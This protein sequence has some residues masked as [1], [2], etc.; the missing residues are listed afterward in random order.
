MLNLNYLLVFFVVLIC[1]G[2]GSAQDP[3][4]VRSCYS[5]A[6]VQEK[7]NGTPLNLLVEEINQRVK[8]NVQVSHSFRKNAGQIVLLGAD[9]SLPDEIVQS[10]EDAFP[11]PENE[12]GYRI[13]RASNTIFIQSRGQRGLQFGIGQILREARYEDDMSWDG[14][15]V[16]TAPEKPIRGHQIGYRNTANSYDAWTPEV[17]EQYIRDLIVFGTNSI[18][19]IPF[20]DPVPIHFTI[21][22]DSMNRELG[23]L[24]EKYDLDY[25]IWTPITFDL[26]DKK[27]AEA[28]LKD[29]EALYRTSPRLDAVFVPGGDPGNNP[30]ELVLPMME[31]MAALVQEHHPEAKMWLS[32][33]G[34]D[35]KD[36]KYVY[37]YMDQKSPTWMG[38]LVAGPGSPP[39][40]E[41][42]A[43]LPEHYPLRHYPDITHTVR[44]QY[45]N[46]WWDPA[47]NFTL[48]R[49]PINPQPLRYQNIFLYTAPYTDGFVTYSDGMHDD[50][51]KMIWSRLGWQSTADIH[52]VVQEYANY[53]LCSPAAEEVADALFALE[54]NWDGAVKNNGS[55]PA[56]NAFWKKI[57]QTYQL[58][59][60]WT[61]WRWKMYMM[62]AEYDAWIQERFRY[63]EQLEIRANDI[64]SQVK[65]LGVEATMDSVRSILAMSKIHFKDHEGR[66]RIY[67][68]GD[69]LFEVIGF[70]SSVPLY[71]ARNPERGAIIDFIDRPLNN[72]WW[73]LAEFD[74]MKNWS[75]SEK[76]GRLEEMGQ[77]EDAG[78]GG[79]YDDIGNINKSP[80]VVKL[81]AS[82]TDPLFTW[83]DNPG[84]DWWE[85]GYSKA[86]LSWM[87][88]MRWPYGLHYRHLD[89]E[90]TY[91]LRLT[92]VGDAFPLIGDVELKPTKYGKKTGDIKEFPI[93][94]NFTQSGEVM[95][96]FK[97]IDESHLN[98][99]KHSRLNEAWLIKD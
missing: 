23:R 97:E 15:S 12:E 66:R 14:V 30:P 64:M 33:Q 51:N 49:E 27:K 99:R 82:D 53:F 94:K 93:P 71:Q 72:E 68:W 98:W 83:S 4:V 3:V 1:S 85:N 35:P 20:A 67:N 74:R 55:I 7:Y 50:L 18:E 8:N 10:A 81:Q 80:H 63:E 52:D 86:R 24:C 11:L 89:P 65:T 32:M 25:W 77:W 40:S 41:T 6:S 59:D 73:I 84:F 58:D 39:L 13:V 78:A 44:C 90:A 60:N 91:T 38:G 17:Y 48:G 69:D 47:F 9:D 45:P 96:Q 16:S 29:C 19:N 62:R 2:H 36:A 75:E 22:A 31:R 88:S 61:L 95:I 87:S 26:N 54:R 76:A 34:F 21:S 42:R 79:Y 5:A 28:Y 70:Q 37:D 92:G 46:W 43:A 57:D 56:T